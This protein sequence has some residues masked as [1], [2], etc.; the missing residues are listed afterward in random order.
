MRKFAACAVLALVFSTFIHQAAGAFPGS[1]YMSNGTWCRT[2]FGKPHEHWGDSLGKKSQQ[3]AYEYAVR[4]WSAFVALEYGRKYADF[5][6]ALKKHVD[7]KDDHGAWGCMIKAQ[8][9]RH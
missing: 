4:N 7:C 2:W 1:Q 9:C 5:G 6:L 3:E 8:A